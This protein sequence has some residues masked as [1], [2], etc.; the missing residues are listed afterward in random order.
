MEVELEQRNHQLH[1]LLRVLHKA[2]LQLFGITHLGGGLGARR[3]VRTSGQGQKSQLE[4]GRLRPLTN[5]WQAVAFSSR[6]AVLMPKLC[7]SP[8]LT[9]S[10]PSSSEMFSMSWAAGQR[11]RD[12][13]RDHNEKQHTKVKESYHTTLHFQFKSLRPTTGNRH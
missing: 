9:N 3:H 1:H 11:P 10:Q 4:R 7:W 5:I 13:S 2:L 8:R 6:P 12:T